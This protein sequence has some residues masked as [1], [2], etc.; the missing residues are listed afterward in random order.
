MEFTPLSRFL[1]CFR[2]V[3]LCLYI[4]RVVLGCPTLYFSFALQFGGT[5][6]M[7]RIHI[8]NFSLLLFKILLNLDNVSIRRAEQGNVQ[9]LHLVLDVLV[10]IVTVLE[11]QMWLRILDTKHCAKGMK[12][13]GK[14]CHVLVPSLWQCGPLYVFI[15][16]ASDKVVLILDGVPE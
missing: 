3:V 13:I 7:L 14:L 10:Q 11:Y 9:E 2:C 8:S 12:N 4:W 15:L 5:F 16:I 6:P 1:L